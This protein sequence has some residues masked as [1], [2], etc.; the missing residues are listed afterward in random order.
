MVEDKEDK[1]KLIEIKSINDENY[2]KYKD[3]IEPS[4]FPGEEKELRESQK[5]ENCIRLFPHDND[6]SNI[7]YL[8]SRWIFY[9]CI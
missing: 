8:I 9:Y 5:L 3:L 2:I 4:C 1:K 6:T 7:K